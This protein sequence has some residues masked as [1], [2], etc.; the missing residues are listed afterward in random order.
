M[1]KTNFSILEYL[2]ENKLV[3]KWQ[4]PESIGIKT[5]YKEG[6]NVMLW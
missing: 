2:L 3:S 5:E 6:C 1:S 4:I